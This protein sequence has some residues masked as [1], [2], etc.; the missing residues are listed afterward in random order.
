[1]GALKSFRRRFRWLRVPSAVKRVTDPVVGRVPVRIRSGVN[2]GLRWSLASAGGGYGSG[3]RAAAQMR[4]IAGLIRDG[5]VVWDV[6]AHHGFVTLAAAREVGP[7]GQVHAF[8]PSLRNRWFLLRHVRWNGLENVR[9]HPYAL[10]SFDGEASL[11]GGSTSKQRA[12]GGEG[13]VVAVRRPGT[14]LGDGTCPAPELV[15]VDVEGA[16]ADVL[17]EAVGVLGPEARLLVAVHSPDL[18]DACTAMLHR[19]GYV[20]LESERM[21][22]HRAGRWSGDADL[23]AYRPGHDRADGDLRLLREAGFD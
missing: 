16:E 4:L 21:R 7:E 6:G 17:R 18:Y 23:F 12:L 11:G 1:M 2:E 3:R 9:V 10:S 22:A 8:E 13:E 20:V 15:K 5:D 14:L 19:A